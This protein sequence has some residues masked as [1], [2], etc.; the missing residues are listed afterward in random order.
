MHPRL[1]IAYPPGAGL[2]AWEPLRPP[3][4]RCPAGLRWPP[5][6][7]GDANT[8]L[9]ESDAVACDDG[10][11]VALRARPRS[12]FS[13]IEL[14]PVGPPYRCESCAGLG[15]LVAFCGRLEVE[16]GCGQHIVM[17]MHPGGFVEVG[18]DAEAVA[19]AVLVDCPGGSYY[20]TSYSW[21][22]VAADRG[23]VVFESGG[24]AV[25][26][27]GGALEASRALAGLAPPPGSPAPIMARCSGLPCYALDYGGFVVVAAWN[28]VGS[29]AVIEVI[30]K[31][32]PSRALVTDAVGQV[33]V[34]V[35]RGLARVFVAG[36]SWAYL[37]LWKKVGL[38]EK[39]KE[40]LGGG[41]A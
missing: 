15:G 36:Y 6:R 29:D 30:P 23:R 40:R 2:K 20:A 14:A 19:P 16:T 32:R 39:L 24:P 41:G 37:V 12:T 35:E 1:G 10:R 18:V 25:A 4:A 34:P 22:R 28:P 13:V 3:T 31:F 21:V 5:P 7:A 17:A 27:R 26:G 11:V 33:E 9:H 8:L 38:A